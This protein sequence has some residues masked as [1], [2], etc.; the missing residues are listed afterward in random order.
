MLRTYATALLH[1]SL[2]VFKTDIEELPV[3]VTKTA[4]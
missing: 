2:A 1:F 3:E 4:R